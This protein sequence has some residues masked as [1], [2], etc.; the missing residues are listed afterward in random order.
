MFSRM[1]NGKLSKILHIISFLGQPEPSFMKIS[2]L[3]I[4]IC[5][6]LFGCGTTATRLGE[7]VNSAVNSQERTENKLRE[8]ITYDKD[9]K[10][11]DSEKKRQKE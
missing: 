2:L 6:L 5:F 4:F 8:K 7:G 11:E 10:D 9:R 1:I 3:P